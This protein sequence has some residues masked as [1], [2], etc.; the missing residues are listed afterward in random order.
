MLGINNRRGKDLLL[1]EASEVSLHGHL[2]LCCEEKNNGR[3]LEREQSFLYYWNWGIERAREQGSRVKIHP[4]WPISSMSH[5]L[6]PF[7]NDS[8]RSHCIYHYHGPI[9]SQQGYQ[10]GI[11]FNIS[12]FRDFLYSNHNPLSISFFKNW[13]KKTIVIASGVRMNNSN[14]LTSLR[15]WLNRIC[16]VTLLYN[17]TSTGY[18]YQSLLQIVI[19][20][21]S[22]IRPC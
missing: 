14:S 10:L 22:Q 18:D 7:S 15:A 2:V 16:K 13:Q 12:I 21:C 9:T 8:S 11:N 1:P 3:E 19:G 6:S 20:K 17:M 5:T 4:Q